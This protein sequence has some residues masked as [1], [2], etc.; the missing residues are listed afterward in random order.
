MSDEDNVGVALREIKSGNQVRIG[1]KKLD[2]KENIDFGH[3]FAISDI[4]KGDNVIKYGEIIGVA[5]SNISTGEHVHVHNVKS[6]RGGKNV[7]S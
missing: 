1:D 3:K 2:L 4:R 7:K 6:L 5:A